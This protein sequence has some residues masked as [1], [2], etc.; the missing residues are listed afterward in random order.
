MHPDLEV[1][2]SADEEARS[3]VALAEQ[4]RER[5]LTAARGARDAALAARRQEA[6][7]A[8]E[9]ELRTIAEA[10]DA[11]EAE[12]ERQQKQYLDSLDEAGRRNFEDAVALYLRIVCEAAS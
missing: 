6:T 9:R 10:G 2:V 1:L 7:D 12:L 8:L 3:R 11:R 4:R 5:E